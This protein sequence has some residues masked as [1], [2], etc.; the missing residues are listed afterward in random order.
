MR[1]LLFCLLLLPI[2]LSAQD[3][4][5]FQ[6]ALRS[7]REHA[8]DRWMARE[9]HRK[10]KGVI[11]ITWESRYT[12]HTA[13]YDSLLAFLRHQT[14]V[15]DAAWDKCMAKI[16]I[17]PGHSTIGMRWQ[18]GDRVIE[19]CWGVQ[20]GLPGTIKLFG[21]RPRVRKTREHLRYRNAREC[22]GFVEQQKRVCADLAQ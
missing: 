14:G 2:A 6:R 21:W 20:E 1:P 5:R 13:T 10:R 7:G 8:L 4:K 19:R 18:H 11:M 3:A 17:W 9:V 15:Q 16:D 22:A 12:S